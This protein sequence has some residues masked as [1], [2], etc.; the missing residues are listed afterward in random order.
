M[1]IPTKRN[2][3]MLKV[4]KEVGFLESEKQKGALWLELECERQVPA[5]DIA[6]IVDETDNAIRD[7]R[8]GWK[9]S[10]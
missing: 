4:L 8:P 3:E 5:S 6:R 2:G 9:A 7:A 1:F 10:V